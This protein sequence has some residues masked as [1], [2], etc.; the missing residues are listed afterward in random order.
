VSSLVALAAAALA[1]AGPPED[2]RF[3]DLNGEDLWARAGL[4]LRFTAQAAIPSDS[5]LFDPTSRTFAANLFL[6]PQATDVYPSGILFF[7]GGWEATGWLGFRLDVDTGL[8][9]NQQLPTSVQV[10]FSN[11][12]PS[13][14]VVATPAACRLGA[15]GGVVTV[16]NGPLPT[17]ELAA[18]VITS[19]GQPIG[20]EFDQ[21]LFIRQLYADFTVGPAGFFRARVGRQRLRVAEGLVYD[22]WGLGVDLDADIGAVGPPL[23]ASLSAFYPTRGWP[24]P[25]QWASPVLAATLDWLP[26]LGQWVGVWAAFSHD[27]TG[28]ANQVLR[29]GFIATEVSAI[30]STTPGSAAYI[31]ASRSL[32][33]LI[34]SPP[35]STSNLGWAGIS[36]RIDVGDRNEARFTLASSF[37]TVSSYGAGDSALSRAVD[38]PVLGWGVSLR[39]LSQL[40]S[41][42]SLSPFFIWLTGDDPGEEQK[43]AL[44]VPRKHTGFLSISPFIGATNLFF[45]G[46]ISEA[47]SDRRVA[48]S[49]VNAR[50]VV[51]PGLEAGWAPVSNLDVGLKGAWLWSDTPGPYGGQVYGPE[52]DL[53]VSWS[54]WPFFAVL[55]EFDV[56]AQGD[57][58]PQR[59]LGRQV[60]LGVDLTTP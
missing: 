44:G 35:L 39:W 8:V 30:L 56:L 54:P 18:P 16:L 26:A 46:G 42:F 28:D 52:V 5:V 57:F 43:A 55:G 32:A 13:G 38:V 21:T 14:I 31:R 47:Y 6:A 33:L 27:E 3:P 17:T 60:I 9:Q 19:N 41:G 7:S 23:A 49:G 12:S 50:G 45:Q 25:S 1:A 34:A 29:Q 4:S 15:P 58:F 36:G 51:A 2:T 40:G 20:D 11:R 59:A 10:C 24:T 53:N 37:G 48:S 22:D